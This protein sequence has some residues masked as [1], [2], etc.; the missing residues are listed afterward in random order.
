M[1]WSPVLSC[2][3]NTAVSWQ[4]TSS[5]SVS[6]LAQPFMVAAY[7]IFLSVYANERSNISLCSPS[8]LAK[9]TTF[10]RSHLRI[11]KCVT[12]TCQTSCTRNRSTRHQGS[13]SRDVKK[14]LP[15][16][17]MAL[18]PPST[19]RVASPSGAGV[20]WVAIAWRATFTNADAAE[21]NLQNE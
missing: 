1:K 14:Q 8:H 16:H 3:S 21:C 12:V 18:V 7:V 2:L 11:S 19:A 6:M 5:T 15:C 10:G 17:Q 9:S 20:L 4:R 13:C